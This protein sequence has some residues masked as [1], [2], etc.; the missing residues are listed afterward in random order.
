MTVDATAAVYLP[1]SV[2]DCCG[3]R[4]YAIPDKV[5]IKNQFGVW[6]S[7]WSP[8]VNQFEESVVGGG[9]LLVGDLVIGR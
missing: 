7:Q 3:F 6:I 4:E 5:L 9:R 2:R 8:G 1:L